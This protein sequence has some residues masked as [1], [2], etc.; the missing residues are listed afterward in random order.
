[1]ATETPSTTAENPL[2]NSLARITGQDPL[3]QSAGTSSLLS[4]DD[5]SAGFRNPQGD[6]ISIKSSPG[7]GAST[8]E[9]WS[10]EAELERLKQSQ[11]E[12]Q[13][14]QQQNELANA[15]RQQ[16]FQ[17]GGEKLALDRAMHEATMRQMQQ[18][19][20]Q[21]QEELA[22][23]RQASEIE[24]ANYMRQ[25]G[26]P[27]Y[28]TSGQYG[29]D[30]AYGAMYGLG[31]RITANAYDSRGTDNSYQAMLQ[32]NQTQAAMEHASP[33]MRAAYL[34]GQQDYRNSRKSAHNP[35]GY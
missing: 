9:T 8:A 24:R 34:R 20:Q 18:Q 10:H 30:Q 4:Y 28:Y 16:E 31:N 12:F 13:Y 35:Y 11:L 29:R 32:F 23:K 14:S 17:R 15:L 19:Y 6:I 2:Q 5:T 33:E 22:L 26:D 27:S 1:M 21:G 7:T 3:S 25:Y